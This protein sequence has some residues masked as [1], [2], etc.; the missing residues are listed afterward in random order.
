MTIAT[1]VVLV[2]CYYGYNAIGG[3]VGTATAMSTSTVLNLVA[4]NLIGML[5]SRIF[6]CVNP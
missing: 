1:V 5:G 3:P 2:G 4:L 6:S